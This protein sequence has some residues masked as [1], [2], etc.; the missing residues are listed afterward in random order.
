MK[1]EKDAKEMVELIPVPGIVKDMV[2][3]YAEKLARKAKSDT[4]T[5][6]ELQETREAYM[7]LLG[8]GI[9]ERISK[10]QEEGI[11]EKSIDPQEELNKGPT[12][13]NIELCHARFFGCPRQVIDVVDLGKKVKAKLEEVKLTEWIAD[14]T[15][16]AF[17]PHTKFTVSISSCPNICTGAEIRDFGI[18]GI[19]FPAVSEVECS[20]CRKCV[21]VCPDHAIV[22]EE[23]GPHIHFGHCKFCEACVQ[24]CPTGTLVSSKRGYRVLVGG[25]FGRW[26][27]DGKEL[28]K[29][30]DEALVLKAL[31]SAISFLKAEAGPHEH[32]QNLVDRLGIE[33]IYRNL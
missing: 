24:E 29:I 1:W 10:T 11:S 28:F 3:L 20:H 6:K 27:T 13:Y 2:K 8:K 21:E 14:K 5:M 33:P 12:L 15:D 31:E 18:H 17:L 7:E 23:D 32:M 9:S 25:R 16:E 26:H 4:V 22:L 19:S 30:G